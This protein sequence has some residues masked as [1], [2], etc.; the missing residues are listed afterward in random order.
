M[1]GYLLAF[2]GCPYV[3]AT[4]GIT[5]VS[6]W[7]AGVDPNVTIVEGALERPTGTLA[8]RLRPTEG[9]CE[10]SP[11]SFVIHDV[12]HGPYERI[13]TGLLALDAR[14]TPDAYITAAASDSDAVLS[15]VSASGSSLPAF[16]FYAWVNQECVLVTGT[17]GTPNQYSVT[18]ARFNSRARAI[19]FDENEGIIPEVYFRYPGCAR[20]RT[21]LYRITEPS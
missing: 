3:F 19:E 7:P 5:A 17:T 6:T 8:E 10:V 13:V 12:A 14:G 4:A 15:F 1:S 20:A 11:L 9:D 2:D 18:R 21:V 16:P